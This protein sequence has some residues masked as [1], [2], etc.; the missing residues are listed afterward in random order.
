MRLQLLHWGG[1]GSKQ[2]SFVSTGMTESWKLLASR[3]SVSTVAGVRKWTSKEEVQS[4]S[5]IWLFNMRALADGGRDTDRFPVSGRKGPQPL[6]RIRIT[7]AKMH[8]TYE[9]EVF[10]FIHSAC[11]WTQQTNPPRVAVII[12]VGCLC[13]LW[14]V[15]LFPHTIDQLRTTEVCGGKF[16][17]CDKMSERETFSAFLNMPQRCLSAL[18]SDWLPSCYGQS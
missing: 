2:S 18:R 6:A 5:H 11:D 15:H 17:Y 12:Y 13:P 14:P 10:K 4:S 8:V 1:L 7:L 3:L 16:F 9:S